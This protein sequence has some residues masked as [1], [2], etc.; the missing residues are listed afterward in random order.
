MGDVEK[1]DKID[2]R[3]FPWPKHVIETTAKQF[4]VDHL[5][6]CCMCLKP[7]KVQIMKNSGVCSE[8]CRKDRDNDHVP[9][10]GGALAP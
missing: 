10:R 9:F 5:N 2:D 3:K 4:N 1:M 6:I 8:L 7:I